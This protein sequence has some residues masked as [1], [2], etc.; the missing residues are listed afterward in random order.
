MPSQVRLFVRLDVKT[1]IFGAFVMRRHTTIACLNAIDDNLFEKVHAKSSSCCR[2]ELD[3]QTP[4]LISTIFQMILGASQTRRQRRAHRR[5]ARF[6]LER[7]QRSVFPRMIP[8]VA[9]ATLG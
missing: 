8:R 2:R 7:L 6:G 1:I 4:R 9:C 5:C 3:A